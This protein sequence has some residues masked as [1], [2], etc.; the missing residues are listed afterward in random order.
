MDDV[1]FVQSWLGKGDANRVYLKVTLQGTALIPY[2][3]QCGVR[4]VG[5]QSAMANTDPSALTFMRGKKLAGAKS[6][7]VTNIKFIF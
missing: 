7:V 2:S 5:I 3:C 6:V 1:I 4:I